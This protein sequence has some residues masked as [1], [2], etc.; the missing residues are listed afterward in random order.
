MREQTIIRAGGAALVA[1]AVA[2]LGVFAFL[3]A[4]FDYPAVLDGT[5]AEVLPRLLA[6]GATGRAVWAVYGFLP[7]IWIPAGVGTFHAFRNLREGSTRA[8]MLFAT[9]AAITMML[10]LLRWPSVHWRLAEA[11]ARSGEP[12]RAAIATVFGGL[13]SYLGNYIGEF[14]GELCV[15]LFFL[16]SAL[17]MLERNAGFPRWMGYLGATTATAG[18]V[19]MFRNVTDVVAPIAA[20]NNYL[21]PLWMIVFGAGLL[22]F[23]GRTSGGGAPTYA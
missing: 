18:L 2:F 9:L 1:G 8:G 12:E 5:A 23:G 4:R 19:G 13:N 16:L 20:V 17:A 15:S 21:L 7:L 14:L 22:R 10:G 3:A 11:Y 6:T